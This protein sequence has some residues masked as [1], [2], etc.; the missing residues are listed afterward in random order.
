MRGPGRM[1]TSS[2][3]WSV[4]VWLSSVCLRFNLPVALPT[5]RFLAEGEGRVLD[6]GAGSGRSTL[7]VLASR[8]R[9]RVVALDRYSGY[10]GI[11]DN[12]PERLLSNARVAGADMRVETIVGD[13][14]AM[15][16]QAGAF[17]A[18][19]S[20]AA[21]DH[22]SRADVGRALGEVSRVL[23]PNGEFLLVVINPDVWVQIAFPFLH[24]HGYFGG[25]SQPEHWREQLQVAG[26]SVV[27]EGTKPA[28][29]FFL[30]RA[31]KGRRAAI[32]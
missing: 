7:M 21:I 11:V 13:M 6:V 24:A 23:K 10:F 19:V 8:P 1:G 29:L 2:R 27:E 30:T 16:L 5:E 15:P 22:L 9:A 18:V 3:P 28:T 14:R 32:P 12:T 25:R 4:P 26:F 31:T 17:D 20:V